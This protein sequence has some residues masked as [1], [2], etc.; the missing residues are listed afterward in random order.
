MSSNTACDKR[1]EIRRQNV[2]S[3]A[4]LIVIR[5]FGEEKKQIHYLINLYAFKCFDSGVDETAEVFA[6]VHE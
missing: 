6:E 3:S 2:F 4:I 1:I 5:L